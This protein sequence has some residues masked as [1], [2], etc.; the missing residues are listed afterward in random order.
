MAAR[1]PSAEG[2][3]SGHE[4][5]AQSEPVAGARIRL[6]L[7]PFLPWSRESSRV[8]KRWQHL[9]RT[10]PS[11][12]PDLAPSG[13]ARLPSQRPQHAYRGPAR[14][15]DA[16]LNSAWAHYR[17][18]NFQAATDTVEDIL[19][20]APTL[21]GADR[22]L[23]LSLGHLP[24]ARQQAAETLARALTET[25]DDPMLRGSAL[26]GQLRAGLI[27]TSEGVWERHPDDP[28]PLQELYAVAL[29]LK[30][31]LLLH[32]GEAAGARQAFQTAAELFR[33]NPSAEVSDQGERLAAS[34]VGLVISHLLAGEWTA[35]QTA[36]ARTLGTAHVPSEVGDFA[37]RVYEVVEA[38]ME[39]PP[40]DRALAVAPLADLLETVE[41]RIEFFD[42]SRPVS[43]M[44]E[45]A[46]SAF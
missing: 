25:P 45:S 1:L 11:A 18:G 39:L 2:R 4:R 12:L 15:G 26:S 32:Q 41:V 13:E 46:G 19:R 38:V 17:L 6:R 14:S 31:R 35:A 43:V 8:S 44:W 28:A 30:G 37:R 24:H 27:H 10:P 20:V 16:A 33:A 3:G 34:Y 23:G 36:Y 21:A 5:W 9:D 40:A 7:P 22:L 29:W 42:N